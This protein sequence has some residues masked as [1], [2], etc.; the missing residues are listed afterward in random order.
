M[1]AK[2]QLDEQM[3]QFGSLVS[4]QYMSEVKAPLAEPAILKN[5]IP[6]EDKM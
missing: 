1:E 3:S 5:A 6:E 2:G 4:Q